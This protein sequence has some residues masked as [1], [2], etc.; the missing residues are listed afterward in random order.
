MFKKN[1]QHKCKYYKC[2]Y[3]VRFSMTFH[4]I[5]HL[6]QQQLQKENMALDN[7]KSN[8]SGQA[9]VEDSKVHLSDAFTLK[10]TTHT[11][12]RQ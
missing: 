11:H 6:I 4:R 3:L 10:D 9:T 12:L 2:K 1:Q 8:L 7:L 5:L